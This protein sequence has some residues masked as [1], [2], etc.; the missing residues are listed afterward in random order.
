VTLSQLQHRIL[1]ALASNRSPAS[2]I[3]GGAALNRSRPRLSD[4]ID[5][6]HDAVAAVA[7][8][9]AV[10]T[11]TLQARGFEVAAP[12]G[13]SLALAPGFVQR[14]V[15]QG[16]ESTLLQWAYDSAV[17]FLPPIADPLFGWRLADADLAVNKALA[18]AGRAAARDVVD[19]LALHDAGWPLAALAWAAPGKD[20]GLTPDTLLDWITRHAAQVPAAEWSALRG[21]APVDPV[22]IRTA[23]L[24]AVAEARAI[25]RRLPAEEVGALFLNASGTAGLPIPIIEAASR[26]LVRHA[27]T[28][29]GALPEFAR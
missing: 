9:A 20:P 15:H 28:I 4:D 2:F 5:I 14:T 18:A 13:Q 19:L 12:P 3:A 16:G 10:D 6:F 17:R 1:A 27:P 21:V 29:G 25:T 22:A 11:A 26:G 7:A 23:L 8:A 24:S